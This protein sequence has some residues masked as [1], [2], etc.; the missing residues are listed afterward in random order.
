M[1]VT[2]AKAL[3]ECV[4]LLVILGAGVLP[5]AEPGPQ[6]FPDAAVGVRADL[7]EIV[8]GPAGVDVVGGLE[9]AV[10]V[11]ALGGGGGVVGE[12]HV[13]PCLPGAGVFRQ[14]VDE[15]LRPAGPVQGLGLGL[16]FCWPAARP[17]A[18]ECG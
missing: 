3:E 10:R 4:E 7:S 1:G 15:P 13:G 6:G 16:E 12:V 2:A 9:V 8:R 18:R 11:E 5:L 14:E 17:L